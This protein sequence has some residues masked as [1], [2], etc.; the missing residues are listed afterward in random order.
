MWALGLRVNEPQGGSDQLTPNTPFMAAHQAQVVAAAAA[1]TKAT[2]TAGDSS[3]STGGRFNVGDVADYFLL[4]V[5]PLTLGLYYLGAAEI[6]SKVPI[7]IMM[8][9][10]FT[11]LSYRFYKVSVTKS[12]VPILHVGFRG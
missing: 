5:A 6:G 7:Y 9:A 1:T 2:A 3:S 4:A 11:V 12:Q 10:V 8:S